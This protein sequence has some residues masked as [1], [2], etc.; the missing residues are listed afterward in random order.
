M[1]LIFS[2]L[3]LFVLVPS[4]VTSLG[5]GRVVQSTLSINGGNAGALST[6]LVYDK[7]NGN[8][9][10][11]MN[12]IQLAFNGP[13]GTTAPK[14]RVAIFPDSTVN[15]TE[16]TKRARVSIYAPSAST[17]ATATVAVV[18]SSDGQGTHTL[19][20]TVNGDSGTSTPAPNS[21]NRNN[22]ATSSF[23][24]I[25]H[26]A[27]A[28][29]CVALNSLSSLRSTASMVSCVAFSS[30]PYLM[31][32]VTAQPTRT[33]NTCDGSAYTIVI[34]VAG[35]GVKPLTTTTAGTVQCDYND[36]L[37]YG[38]PECAWANQPTPTPEID[39]FSWG[40]ETN[41]FYDA[42]TTGQYRSTIRTEVWARF[43]LRLYDQNI[44][45]LE[46]AFGSNPNATATLTDIID[47]SVSDLS[48]FSNGGS[49]RYTT[50]IPNT[51][52]QVYGG[53]YMPVA[54]PLA[55][56]DI[57]ASFRMTTSDGTLQAV[58]TFLKPL[59]IINAAA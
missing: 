23:S 19:S 31:S 43:N 47:W 40:N 35:V 41:Y 53:W 42:L 2:L 5:C 6:E 10:E 13:M 30:L 7:T 39:S 56:G 55:N 36:D 54:K 27:V 22:T 1:R 34:Q 25:N 46:Y 32:D 26:G 37:T 3:S 15:K 14:F 16:N 17:P 44:T 20:F 33:E 51:V 24:M 11:Y 48:L 38:K 4:C 49:I 50:G 18:G 21:G 59:T 58:E 57:Y 12:Q 29:S 8:P 9:S 28:A 45:K 52:S